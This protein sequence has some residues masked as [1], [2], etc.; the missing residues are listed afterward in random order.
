MQ[1]SH[2]L[3]PHI[4]SELSNPLGSLLLQRQRL[5]QTSK[6]QRDGEAGPGSTSN[7]LK[8]TG[9]CGLEN[10]GRGPGVGDTESGDK[11][12]LEVCQPEEEDDGDTIFS[13]VRIPGE[14]DPALSV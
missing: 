5:I 9:S 10:G 11:L 3:Y 7:S 4:S 1:I 14:E 8:R 12:G 13:P 2:T 6:N